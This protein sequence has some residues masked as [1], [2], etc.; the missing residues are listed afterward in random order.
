MFEDT[1]GDGKADNF[2]TFFEGTTYTMD[3]AVHPD[4]SVYVATRNEIL[5]LRDTNGD[6][7]ADEKTRIV[8]LDTKGNYPHNGLSG[9]SL[10]LAAAISTS[11]W[12]R[13]SAQPY[14]LIGSDGTTLT[15]GG[16]GGNVFHCTADGKKLR[17][18]ATG[19]WNPF[20]SCRDI[21]GRLFA[22]DN[23]PDAIAAVPAAARRRGRRLR[24]PV[25]LR[26]RGP[27]SVP[28]V[29]RRTARHA[30]DGRAA[31]ANRRARSSA[32][33]RTACREYRGNLLVPAWADH[34][35]ERYVLEAEGG[36]LHGGAQAVH[37]GREGLLPV[38]HD[39]RA[40]RLAVRQRLGLAR[41]TNCTA[42][43]RSGTSAG[44]TRSR[45]SAH[46]PKEAS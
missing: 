46:D 30:A 9:L 21:F 6:G 3:L 24:L 15:G 43:A 45:R 37:P 38:G 8:F 1:D 14:K 41:A 26:P 7:K 39:G 29:E 20:G 44:R 10:R 19:F 2:T 5:R 4:G 27:A 16:E 34:R 42:R 31:P 32:T 18:V 28:G 40:G 25:P 12:A 17:R 13:T 35:V 11:A 33:S 23:D 22:V 36:E